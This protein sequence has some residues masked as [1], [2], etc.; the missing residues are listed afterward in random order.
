MF[1]ACG[2]HRKPPVLWGVDRKVDTRFWPEVRHRGNGKRPGDIRGFLLSPSYGTWA[3][4]WRHKPLGVLTCGD[5]Q[6][7]G[8]IV[9]DCPSPLV[10][11][12]GP[13]A[14]TLRAALEM[15]AQVVRSGARGATIGRN[16]WGFHQIEAAVQ[17]FKAVIHDGK[18][19][20][21]ALRQAGL[22]AMVEGNQ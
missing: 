2:G 5:V 1:G 17:A 10:A 7:Y 9:A 12:G 22:A 19:P 15:V 11:A 6:A 13:K 14:D 8:Q 20:N 4:T 21:E 18:S 16:I 3:R